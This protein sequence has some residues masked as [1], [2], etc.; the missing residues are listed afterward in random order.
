MPAKPDSSRQKSVAIAATALAT[1]MLLGGS[2]SLVPLPEIILQCLLAGFT[3]AWVWLCP[4]GL[5]QVP[6]GAW[7]IAA[8][9]L[10]IPLYQLLPMPPALWHGLPGRSV[11]Q[12]ALALVGQGSSW[13]PLSLT[14]NRTVAALLAV[15]A[16]AAV[17]VMAA[18]QDRRGRTILLA[19]MTGAALLSVLVGAA[20]LSG[21]AGNPFRF[22]YPEEAF[23]D[24]FQTNHNAEADV[25]LIGMVA[26]AAVASDLAN[27]RERPIGPRRGPASPSLRA[28]M[29]K[30]QRQ[31]AFEP[32]LMLGVVGGATLLLALGVVL[33]ASRTG[34]ALLPIA[35][36]AQAFILRR[37]L[38]LGNRRMWGAAVAAL[39]MLAIAAV[40]LSQHGALGRVWDRFHTS[41]EFRPEIWRDALFAMRQ[42][43]P[44]GAGMGSFIPVFAAAERLEVVTGKFVNRAHDDYLEF[45]I[46][47]G[48]PGI[49]V[50]GLIFRQIAAG[51]WHGWRAR[52]AGSQAQLI[53]GATN[54]FILAAHSLGDYP[55][56]TVSIACMTAVNAGL[57][58]PITERV[59]RGSELNGDEV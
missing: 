9:M 32:R 46:E 6:R 20:Q 12:A 34:I 49:V 57:L 19:T 2:G 10:A 8:L 21:G 40:S 3:V 38:R 11:E 16:A 18:A 7:I 17:L 5:R 41:T 36:G 52:V 50:L 55:L 27:R 26:L 37:W 39:A 42:Y 29:G 24:G 51:A 48:L 44:W 35:I 1:A 15:T 14:P 45:L 54:L 31:P 13:Q 56:R 4:D 47:A 59:A 30:P 23:L 33:T 25:L 58:L 43:W 53:C 28:P 22:Y